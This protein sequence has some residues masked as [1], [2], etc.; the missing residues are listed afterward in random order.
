MINKTE[1]SFLNV[2]S[3]IIETFASFE[4]KDHSNIH[5]DSWERDEGGGGKTRAN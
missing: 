5:F 3:S 1:K 4:D 2:Q